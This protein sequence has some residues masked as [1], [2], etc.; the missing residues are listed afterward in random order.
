VVMRLHPRCIHQGPDALPGADGHEIGLAARGADGGVGVAEVGGDAG[1][2]EPGGDGARAL[3]KWMPM[4]RTGSLAA[5]ERCSHLARSAKAL[6]RKGGRFEGVAG[7]GAD[8][9]AAREQTSWK[10]AAALPA[11][12]TG[13]ASQTP[14]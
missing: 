6:V 11:W 7:V 13:E 14:D 5:L 4:S 9:L 8:A 10:R 1:R 12:R 3:A 2:P